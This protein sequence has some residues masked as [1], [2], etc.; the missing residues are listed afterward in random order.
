MEREFRL[1]QGEASAREVAGSITLA[2]VFNSLFV[3]ADYFD[4]APRDFLIMT[5][6]R[7]LVAVLSV[8]CVLM[9]RKHRNFLAAE[10]VLTVFIGV[11]MTLYLP[12]I[13]AN[14]LVTSVAP[15]DFVGITLLTYLFFPSHLKRVLIL[16]TING[17]SFLLVWSHWG[18]PPPTS[19]EAWIVAL[20][21]LLA[22]S[23]GAL[24]AS[25]HGRISRE[26]FL[27]IRAE[28]KSA[29]AA[30][31]AMRQA[32]EA[33]QVKSDFLA[34]MSHEI[35]TP[36]SGILGCAR[37]LM[38]T[39][40]DG[41]Q[42]DYA[43]TIHQSGDALLTILNDILD[44]TKI[45]AGRMEVENM[46]F[47]VGPLVEGVIGLL[48]TR[49]DEKG[50]ALSAHLGRGVPAR[51][52]GD[53][54]RLR[55]ILLNLVGNGVKFTERGS[56]R[57]DVTLSHRDETGLWLSFAVSDTGIGI[58]DHIR[59]HLFHAF[60]QADT[61]ISRRFGGTGLGLAISRRLA[62]LMGGDISVESCP[63]GGSRFVVTMPFQAAETVIEL[64]A[65]TDDL[66][67]IPHEPLRL[68]L[69]EDNP[70]NQ[71]VVAAM[72]RKMG[73]QVTLV[74]DGYEA[75]EAVKAG[76]Y[77]LVLMDVQMPHLDGLEAT[78]RIRALSGE[79]GNI[80]ILALTANALK[81]DDQRCRDAGMN[82]Y[83]VKPVEPKT[84][85]RA[86]ARHG[87]AVLSA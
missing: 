23:A 10:R 59:P 57:V 1:W 75:V 53:P 17:S 54:T 58:P 29:E 83:L 81:G 6:A 74:S 13:P 65:I 72:L 56:V 41:V 60:S 64:A 30:R 44:F 62:L 68:L 63:E 84:L 80:P 51:I 73:H 18:S 4:M 77:D 45:E 35:R 21:V 50:L 27:V 22:N 24:L 8:A 12:F 87:V 37:L 40:L 32:E 2:G 38:D 70:V 15:L 52:S 61:S 5:L 85:A 26:H 25:R 69:A 20:W 79:R 3:V 66:T 67:L 48:Q 49:A 16:G 43:A 34:M 82:D 47:S 19:S 11:Y 39:R 7:L 33:A 14:I 42:R 86:L 9:V 31:K 78:A 46:A 55:Q 28:R 71:K 76:V 36:L